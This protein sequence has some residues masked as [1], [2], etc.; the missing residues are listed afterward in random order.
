MGKKESSGI[1]IANLL[2][3]GEGVGE[4]REG[5]GDGVEAPDQHQR[6]LPE[7]LGPLG[8]LC[9]ARAGGGGG[10]GDEAAVLEDGVDAGAEAVPETVVRGWAAEHGGVHRGGSERIGGSGAATASFRIRPAVGLDRGGRVNGECALNR[11]RLRNG[12]N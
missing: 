2:G 9:A 1:R 12:R 11:E 7:P 8:R 3:G 10:G 4:L 6:V 5:G